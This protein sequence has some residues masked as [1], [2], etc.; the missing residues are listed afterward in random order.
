MRRNLGLIIDMSTCIH[1]VSPVWHI[2]NI[3]WHI[4]FWLRKEPITCQCDPHSWKCIYWNRNWFHCCFVWLA[5]V[6]VSVSNVA[7]V[8][9]FCLPVIAIAQYVKVIYM[10]CDLDNRNWWWWW[11]WCLGLSLVSRASMLCTCCVTVLSDK[12]LS[13]W[14]MQI[15]MM[16]PVTEPTWR[17]QVY[18]GVDGY[19]GGNVRVMEKFWLPLW[20]PWWSVWFNTSLTCRPV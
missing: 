20:V 18:W 8:V 7:S 6:F 10:N 11:W 17:V 19:G 1:R 2:T 15:V 16:W 3:E 5:D 4:A 14:D 9:F 13:C 12:L